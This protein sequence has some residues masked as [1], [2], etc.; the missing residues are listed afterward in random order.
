MLRE[1]GKNAEMPKMEKAKPS[2]CKESVPMPKQELKE[3]V[4]NFKEVALGY[5]EEQAVME[6]KRC[7]QCAQ[8]ECME[9]CPVEIDIPIFIKLT[10]E[11][12]FDEAIKKIREQNSL[13]AICGRV[14]PKKSYA[15]KVV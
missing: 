4:R 6:A 14:C 2:I 10:S 8:P 1:G 7:L 3:R 15:R 11:R 13:P 12:K 9:G 5:T